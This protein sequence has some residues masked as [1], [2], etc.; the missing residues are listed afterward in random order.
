MPGAYAHLT[1]VNQAR[2]TSRLESLSGFEGE[3]IS[4][5][6]DYAKYCELGCVS[7]DYPYL[8]LLDGNSKE[9]ADLMHYKNTKDMILAGIKHVKTA[10]NEEQR[11]TFAWLLGYVA[12]VITDIT[13][14]PVVQEIV[15]PYELNKKAHRVCEMNQDV[16]IFQ[17]LN[18]G[19]DV[20]HS[21][22]TDS[23]QNCSHPQDEN[24]L[25]PDIKAAWEYML[26]SVFPSSFDTN[27]PNFNSWHNNFRIMVDN[28]ASEGNKLFAFA[29]HMAEKAGVTY[30]H[31]DSVEKKFLYNLV[32]PHG[33]KNYDY[34]FDHACNNVLEVWNIIARAIYWDDY[35][36][37]GHIEDWNLDT[38]ENL[39][40]KLTMW[41]ES[42][43]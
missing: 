21:E 34:V 6:L 37:I 20:G 2:E 35:G 26:S 30:P 22:F 36:S 18:L 38:G 12:H 16:Y 24:K 19:P 32:T 43:A 23:L 29:R 31:I 40:G 42:F 33:L 8:S 15:G 41:E 13:I 28:I 17:R 25:D 1:L 39:A 7:P 3:Q 4:S 9:W 11:K 5:L 10:A 14:H 27:P